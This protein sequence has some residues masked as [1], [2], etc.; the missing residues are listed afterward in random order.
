MCG[1]WPVLSGRGSRCPV[2]PTTDTWLALNE[3]HTWLIDA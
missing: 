2:T 3:I 1:A